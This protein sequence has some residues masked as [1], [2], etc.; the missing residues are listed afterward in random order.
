MTPFE[1]L[2]GGYFTGVILN[3]I[4]FGIITIQTHLY[5]KRYKSDPLLVKGIVIFL[6]LL[7]GFQTGTSSYVVYTNT[8][9]SF[10]VPITRTD[11]ESTIYQMA[12]VT[13]AVVVQMYYAYRL[14]RLSNSSWL[15]ILVVMLTLAQFGL[16][17]AVCLKS[18]LTHQIEQTVTPLRPL[19]LSWLL[20]EAVVDTLIAA[21]M[22]Y[23]LSRQRTG[24]RETDSAITILTVYAINTGVVTTILAMT[25]MF[26]FA[27]YGYHF[28]H[29]AFVLSLGA[30]YAVSLLANLHSRS[31]VRERL[32]PNNRTR[33]RSIHFSRLPERIRDRISQAVK[34]KSPA[35][36]SGVNDAMT[37]VPPV[38]E[39]QNTA[40]HEIEIV[41]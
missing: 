13:C 2:Y 30:V 6:I 32:K 9:R 22:W 36:A 41:G 21:S 27:F 11:W 15:S 40:T 19:I 35:T 16:A 12:T 39:V 4:L 3:S 18:N 8:I 20:I 14:Y 17:L 33:A 7:Q 37:A 10:G 23:F 5:F 31:I 26:A 25:V 28:I 38:I 24:F 29:M 1:H 34:G